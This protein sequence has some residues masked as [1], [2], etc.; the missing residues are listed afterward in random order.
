MSE[1]SY[2]ESIEHI[3]KLIKAERESQL[4]DERLA[5]VRETYYRIMDSAQRAGLDAEIADLANTATSHAHFVQRLEFTYKEIIEK[6][7]DLEA[8]RQKKTNEQSVFV[9]VILCI[10]IALVIVGWLVIK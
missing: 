5:A 2:D 7:P 1:L 9:P 4:A 8:Y 10:A 6:F 3:N